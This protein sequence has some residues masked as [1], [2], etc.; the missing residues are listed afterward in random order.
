MKIPVISQILRNTTSYYLFILLMIAGCTGGRDQGQI[1]LITDVNEL[2]WTVKDSANISVTSYMDRGLTKS[3]LYL[4]ADSDKEAVIVLESP[5]IQV[6]AGEPVTFS[7]AFNC[8]S[9]AGNLIE[10][11]IKVMDSEG[12]IL[13]DSTLYS[14]SGRLD[15][16]SL[17]RTQEWQEYNRCIMMP[18]KAASAVI[19]LS[20]QV[21][22]GEVWIGQTSLVSGEGWLDY[23]A[24]FSSHLKEHPE[25]KY[26]FCAIRNIEPQAPPVPSE[27]EKSL[28]YTVFERKYFDD[29][30][31]YSLPDEGSRKSK[32]SAVSCASS[33]TFYTFGV[34]AFEDLAGVTVSLKKPFV[35]ESG[36]L[37]SEVSLMQGKYV[38]ARLGSSWGKEFG[39]K[40]N[41]LTNV[42]SAVLPTGWSM[43]YWVDVPVPENAVPGIYNGVVTVSVEGKEP[44]DLAL[45]LEVLPIVLPK[46]Y[47][48]QHGMYYYP[49]N[50]P[51][52]MDVHLRDMAAHGVYAI[53]LAGSFVE[54]NPAGGVRIDE[55]KFDKL[56]TLMGLMRKHD[57]FRPTALFVED[58]FRILDLPEVA[59][60]W[61]A[62]HRKIYEQA[63]RLMN[64]TAEKND[65]CKLWIFPI[66]EPANSK[67]KMALAHIVLG[68]LRKIPGVIPY[69]DLNSPE[70]VIEMS[71][72]ID[73]ICMQ[74]LSVKPETMSV[75]KE[76]N[77]ESYFYLPAF[78]WSVE[79]HRGIAG[80]FLPSSGA[81]GIYYF[82]YQS[83]TGDPYDELDG[84]HRDWSAAYPAP[85]PNHVWPCP[86]WQGG[87]RVGI[88]DLR[89]Q[90]LA[91][92]LAGECIGSDDDQTSA[93]GKET[94]EMIRTFVES[95][96]PTGTEVSYQFTYEMNEDVFADWNRQIAE[97]VMLM[98]E[99]LQK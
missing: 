20:S 31:P 77:I 99:K 8:K 6:K 13:L 45:E 7:Y 21:E 69:C 25:D 26:V 17:G 72:Y 40:A 80:W 66:D 94:V 60:E 48:Y 57:F 41:L 79:W 37:G 47:G 50:D 75:M 9:A 89:L 56:N 53:S 34:H 24:S 98:Q 29:A 96:K 10:P 38:P 33:T 35:S 85:A 81:T 43:F 92:Q 44:F 19:E 76:K 61:T 70:S 11:V 54:K 16:Y 68:I 71:D 23:A 74:I 91:V 3:A 1:V 64:T 90:Y 59:A 73:V 27:Q 30:V 28:G 84:T 52:L 97:K 87:I 63:I 62:D 93:L 78:G 67:E 12:S 39:I 58:L 86:Q 55:K 4:A 42:E 14:I 95:V 32:F 5:Q 65:W 83:V 2:Q 51:E 82:A 36:E 88:D 22:S 18:E 15:S 49:P 46:E